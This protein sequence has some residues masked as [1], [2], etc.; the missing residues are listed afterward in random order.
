MFAVNSV[1]RWHNRQGAGDRSPALSLCIRT[2]KASK[3]DRRT[4]RQQENRK[5]IGEPEGNRR[6]ARQAGTQKDG[7]EA[8]KTIGAIEGNRKAERRLES[9]KAAREPQGK[10]GR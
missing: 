6:T 4:G 1:D 3:D 7:E 5:A 9:R 10:Q 2:Q 8:E